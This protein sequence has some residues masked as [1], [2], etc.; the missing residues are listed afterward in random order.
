MKLLMLMYSGARK[1]DIE[2]LL[3]AHDVTGYT[4]ISG[5]LGAGPSGRLLGTRAWPGTTEVLMT[6]VPDLRA[7][8]LRGTLRD[9]RDRAP[10]GEHL[11][12]L[13]LPVEDYF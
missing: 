7:D 1:Q 10:E 2:A 12:V 3:D 13:T 6:V 11:H 4:T 9:W 8:V 5:A